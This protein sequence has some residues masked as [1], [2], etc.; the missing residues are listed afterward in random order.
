[1][2]RNEYF[3][4]IV[5]VADKL[6]TRLDGTGIRPIQTA[7]VGLEEL[8]TPDRSLEISSILSASP[9]DRMYIIFKGNTD[10]RREL[11]EVESIKGAMRLIAALSSA[12][13]DV[14]VGFCSSDVVL[15][16]AA[17]ASSCATGKFFNL[18]RFTSSRFEDPSGVVGSS[19]TG[20]RNRFLHLCVSRI[21]SELWIA[22][23]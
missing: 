12:E 6:R 22:A 2:F 11:A 18:R 5:D 1:M 10:P 23:S 17:G 20:S 19:P 13:I 4:L 16:K 3:S 8:T 15:W 14:I 21:L 9:C 7:L